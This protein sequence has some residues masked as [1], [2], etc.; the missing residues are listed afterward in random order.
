MVLFAYAA[1]VVAYAAC[2]VAYAA[3]GIV[4]LRGMR[5]V[6]YAARGIVCSHERE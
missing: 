5:V 2:V 3:R 6:A 1:C 4:C